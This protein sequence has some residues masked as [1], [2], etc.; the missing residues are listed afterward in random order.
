MSADT[1]PLRILF[2]SISGWVHRQQQEVVVTGLIG[3]SV[4]SL[5]QGRVISRERLGGTL[6]YYERAAA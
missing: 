3:G 5:K 4:A 1:L 2:L 6:R